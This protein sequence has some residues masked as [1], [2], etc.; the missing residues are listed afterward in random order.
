ME[1]K[2]DNVIDL[3]WVRL[4]LEAKEIGIPINEIKFFL[5]ENK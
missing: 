4:V 3:E 1:I 5:E 2:Q